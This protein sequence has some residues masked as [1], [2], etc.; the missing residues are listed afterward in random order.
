MT[1]RFVTK[2]DDN[3]FNENPTVWVA[4]KYSKISLY[5]HVNITKFCVIVK[6]A[7]VCKEKETCVIGNDDNIIPNYYKKNTVFLMETIIYLHIE[8][9]G[10]K[11][12]HSIRNQICRIK[13]P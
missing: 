7:D 2:T 12:T 10:K 9:A 8:T 5:K 11:Y 6:F 13:L 4:A 1:S 3:A